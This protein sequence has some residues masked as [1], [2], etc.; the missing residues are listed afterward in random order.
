MAHIAR[1]GIEGRGPS[2]VARGFLDLFDATE[3]APRLEARRFRRQPACLQTLGLSLEMELQFFA[4]FGL[5]A[6][7]KQKRA[8]PAAED[9]PGPHG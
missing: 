4:Q 8:E 3:Q 5:A 1:Q 9:V 6:A 7:A 2:R